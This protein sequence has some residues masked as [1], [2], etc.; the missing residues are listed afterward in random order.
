MQKNKTHLRMTKRYTI[1]P[2]KADIVHLLEFEGAYINELPTSLKKDTTVVI[3]QL[4]KKI[5]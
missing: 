5:K 1:H 2:H 3:L 4:E